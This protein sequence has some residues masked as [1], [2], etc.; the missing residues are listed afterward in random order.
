MPF[1]T[2]CGNQVGGTDVFCARCG[3]RQTPGAPAGSQDFLTGVSP[4]TASILAY[5]PFVG[6]V[7]AIIALAA[8][9]FQDDRIVRFHAFQGVYLFV[10]WLLVDWVVGPMF[11]Y[12]PSPHPARA[13]R[14]LVKFSILITWIFMMVKTSQQQMYRLPIIGELAERSMSEQR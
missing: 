11:G 9:K 1:C 5:V 8:S 14:A 4:Q 7:F 2:N 13:V 6:W 12:I 10:V 3:G